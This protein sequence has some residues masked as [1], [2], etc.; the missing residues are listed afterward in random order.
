M[1]WLPLLNFKSMAYNAAQEKADLQENNEMKRTAEKK[2]KWAVKCFEDWNKYSGVDPDLWVYHKI[3][4][5][6]ITTV[7]VLC[8]F[9]GGTFT[10]HKPPPAQNKN[11][12]DVIITIITCQ[13][14]FSTETY[15]L[16]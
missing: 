2:M 12:V 4:N 9:C 8:T 3:N 5:I 1:Q 6:N 11:N 10:L 14:S 16:F 15:T 13:L 7:F